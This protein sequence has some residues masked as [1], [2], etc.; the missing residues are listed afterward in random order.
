[1]CISYLRGWLDL[2]KKPS[3]KIF[4][5]L[6]GGLLRL[7]LR[8]RIIVVLV[9]LVILWSCVVCTTFPAILVKSLPENEILEVPGK[10]VLDEADISR[11][12]MRISICNRGGPSIRGA[13]YL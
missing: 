12:K 13:L 3:A 2:L 11:G 4:V 7:R 6:L 8:L 10:N 9:L 5:Y 1:M